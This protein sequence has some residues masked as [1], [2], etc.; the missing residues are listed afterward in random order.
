M[1]SVVFMANTFVISTSL[2]TAKQYKETGSL[3]ILYFKSCQQ[4][5]ESRSSLVPALF[6]DG[7]HTMG[8]K[9]FPKVP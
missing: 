2:K 8:N 3:K 5:W 1:F 4:P 7:C 6:R 9:D